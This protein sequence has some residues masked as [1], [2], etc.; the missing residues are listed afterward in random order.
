MAVK[1]RMLLM[2]DAAMQE[3]KIKKSFH[4]RKLLT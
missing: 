2:K 3:K 1:L 4:T